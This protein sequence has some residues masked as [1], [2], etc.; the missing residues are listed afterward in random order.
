MRQLVY[1]RLLDDRAGLEFL[2]VEDLG[3]LGDHGE[4]LGEDGVAPDVGEGDSLV[5]VKL[6]NL[7]EEVL[8]LLGA[9]SHE[10]LL[11][12]LDRLG[13]AEGRGQ[14][15]QLDFLLLWGPVRVEL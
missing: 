6:E 14:L 5:G 13:V 8:D 11:R 7:L 2:A 15:L 4:M 9:V 1:R 10:V 12:L 3:G